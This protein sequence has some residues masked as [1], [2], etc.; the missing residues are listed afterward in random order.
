[1]KHHLS[2]ALV[3]T[4]T[5]LASSACLAHDATS[6]SDQTHAKKSAQ[7]H[8]SWI[9]LVQKHNGSGVK[10]RYRFLDEPRSGQILRIELEIAA[11]E[12]ALVSLRQ[13]SSLVMN[14]DNA[15]EKT[16]TGADLRLAKSG[17]T[18]HIVSVMP[19][20]EGLYFVDVTTSQG[21]KTSVASIA[22]KV[23]DAPV[24]TPTI[25]EKIV[26]PTGEKIISMPAK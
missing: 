8:K 10:L 12:N 26:T 4:L 19:K 21:D 17:K 7:Q 14:M 3:A 15:W 6:A 24:A 11:Q 18:R 23:G 16:R 5:F 1:M 22:V 25:G 2:L 9:R 13:D 20:A